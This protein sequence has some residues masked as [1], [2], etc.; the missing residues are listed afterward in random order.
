MTT[1]TGIISGP[2]YRNMR[3]YSSRQLSS[4]PLFNKRQLPSCGTH[5]HAV[6]SGSKTSW[7]RTCTMESYRI[8]KIGIYGQKKQSLT[9]DNSSF[10]RLTL[11][12]TNAY[13]HSYTP[14]KPSQK[15]SDSRLPPTSLQA[16]DVWVLYVKNSTA[17]FIKTNERLRFFQKRSLANPP[18]KA[19]PMLPVHVGYRIPELSV[20]SLN[21]KGGGVNAGTDRPS[22][23]YGLAETQAEQSFER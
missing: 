23:W 9:Q 22:E 5:C 8:S 3:C 1:Y 7:K 19:I 6:P 11:L 17:S 4:S 15:M 20:Y 14:I 16:V 12:P 13:L 18:S 21:K 2:I 10:E